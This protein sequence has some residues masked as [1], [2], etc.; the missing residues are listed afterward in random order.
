MFA[1]MSMPMIN[2]FV[3]DHGF[4]LYLKSSSTQEIIFAGTFA[5]L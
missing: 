1:A 5:G 3:A 4:V 2:Y